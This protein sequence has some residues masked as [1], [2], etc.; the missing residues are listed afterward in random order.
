M[1]R[2]NL[3][4]TVK[5]F[6]FMLIDY[7]VLE[8][9]V[10]DSTDEGLIHFITNDLFEGDVET[11]AERIKDDNVL[12]FKSVLDRIVRVNITPTETTSYSFAIS[13]V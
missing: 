10:F 13:E 9:Y 1:K 7:S 2:I 11:L 6:S 3:E 5:T 4:R 12:L 8:E